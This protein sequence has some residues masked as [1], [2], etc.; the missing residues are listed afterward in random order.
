M[1][2]NPQLIK[3]GGKKIGVLPGGRIRGNDRA[4]LRG[5]KDAKEKSQGQKTTPIKEVIADLGL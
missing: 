3:K 2:L 4:G 1:E 5:L